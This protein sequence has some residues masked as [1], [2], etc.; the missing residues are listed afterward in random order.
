MLWKEGFAGSR[1]AKT[2]MDEV[3]VSLEPESA[4]GEQWSTSRRARLLRGTNEAR[5]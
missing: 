1:L 5:F 4:E 3:A 2:S